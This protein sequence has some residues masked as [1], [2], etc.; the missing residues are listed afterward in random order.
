LVRL[1]C[2][3]TAGALLAILTLAPALPFLA[4][5]LRSG[6][7]SRS[8]NRSDGGGALDIVDH[9]KY[10]HCSGNADERDLAD[11]HPEFTDE[12]LAPLLMHYKARNFPKSLSE[13]EQIEWEKWRTAKITAE[14]PSFVKSLQKLA[15][16]ADESKQFL[17][18]ELQLWA[19]SIA[20][21]DID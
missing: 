7:G 3:A 12:R 2:A 13:T 10:E 19:E 9:G 6:F 14:L 15:K 17:L 11:F 8:G 18:Q 1:A 21:G 16:T 4:L 5:D 20:P